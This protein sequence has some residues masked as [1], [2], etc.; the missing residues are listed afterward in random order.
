MHSSGPTGDKLERRYAKLRRSLAEFHRSDVGKIGV[1]KNQGIA[2]ALLLVNRFF[3]WRPGNFSWEKQPAVAIRVPFCGFMR[4][5]ALITHIQSLPN[6]LIVVMPVYA[7]QPVVP[8]QNLDPFFVCVLSVTADDHLIAFQRGPFVL[9]PLEFLVATAC[10]QNM[11]RYKLVFV[12][13]CRR[14]SRCPDL[15]RDRAC[16][17]GEW[18]SRPSGRLPA[19]PGKRGPRP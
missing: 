12:A 8:A 1:R 3:E 2:P 18:I 6:A 15:F 7:F 5:I 13:D 14:L 11:A 10:H 16:Q 19:L 4:P 17:S 9:E